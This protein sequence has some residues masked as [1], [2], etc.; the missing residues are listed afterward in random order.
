[1]CGIVGIIVPAHRQTQVDVAELIA[2][3]EAMARRGPDAAGL[4]R[5]EDGRV[6]LAHRRLAVID[7]T[8]EADQ[9][10]A[11]ADGRLVIVFNGEILN[12]R[13]LRREL[14]DQGH[15]FRTRSDTEV[16]LHLYDR[17]GEAMV[18]R[19]RGMYA[20]ALWD[21]GRRRLFAARDPFG[22]LP[23]YYSSAGG[24]IRF[25]SQVKALRR[26]RAISDRLDPAGQAGF[27]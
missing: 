19:L 17:Y 10:M 5:S 2:M 14:E 12:Y 8:P 7:P 6:G 16:L 23:L 25:A 1:M 18:E 9:P 21:A 26:A 22:I 20:F 15:R 13:E 3:R 11:S 24:A 4:W 27:L